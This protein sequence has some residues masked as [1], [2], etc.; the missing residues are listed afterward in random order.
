MKKDA[1]PVYTCKDLCGRT[2]H[3]G[4]FY[5]SNHP[6]HNKM[7]DKNGRRIKPLKQ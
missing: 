1:T 4:N 2:K 5:C 6:D 3:C 7:V